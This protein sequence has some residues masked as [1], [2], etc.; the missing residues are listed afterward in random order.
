MSSKKIT[1]LNS[2]PTLSNSDILYIVDVSNGIYGESNKITY[3]ELAGIKLNNLQLDLNALELIVNGII[4]ADYGT[5]IQ[6]VSAI[7]DN[8][9]NILEQQIT[10]LSTRVDT[11]SDV[12][13]DLTS[14]ALSVNNIQGELSIINSNTDFAEFLVEYAYLS[15]DVYQLSTDEV[16]YNTTLIEEM[17]ANVNNNIS[18]I[19]QV[20][21]TPLSTTST[22]TATHYV[23]VNLGGGTYKML[24]AT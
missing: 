23:N 17:S 3:G 10:L 7:S 8:R 9:D 21:S 22:L 18:Y 11:L 13:N 12:P 2:I 15:T 5:Q 20:S 24:L 16:V 4:A 1:D 19:S 6:Q 14:I